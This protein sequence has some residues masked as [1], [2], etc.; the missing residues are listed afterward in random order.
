AEESLKSSEPVRLLIV[1]DTPY[2]RRLVLRLLGRD[3]MH[4]YDVTQA[5]HLGAALDLLETQAPFD[6]ILADYRLPDGISTELFE[7]LDPR[8]RPAVIVCSG[9]ITLDTAKYLLSLGVEDYLNKATLSVERLSVA[10]HNALFRRKHWHVTSSD[11]GGPSTPERERAFN[12]KHRRS[13]ISTLMRLRREHERYIERVAADLTVLNRGDTYR[14]IQ[15]L[16][17]SGVAQ[18]L[19]APSSELRM[20][21]SFLLEDLTALARTL[22]SQLDDAGLRLFGELHAC[23]TEIQ[24]ATDY[25]G[26]VAQSLSSV[27]AE[28]MVCDALVAEHLM[29]QCMSAVA[30][31]LSYDISLCMDPRSLKQPVLAND[32]ALTRVFVSLFG[33]TAHHYLSQSTPS[34]QAVVDV[35]VRTREHFVS[36]VCT[37]YVHRP[38][39]ENSHRLSLPLHLL[40][41]DDDEFFEIVVAADLVHRMGGSLEIEPM[42]RGKGSRTT[43]TLR[44]HNVTHELAEQTTPDVMHFDLQSNRAGGS[45]SPKNLSSALLVEDN[46]GDVVLFQYKFERQFPGVPLVAV[47]TLSEA[48]ERVELEEPELVFLDLHLP[49]ARGNESLVRLLSRFPW[50]DVI[51]LSGDIEDDTAMAALRSGAQD[52]LVKGGFTEQDL[53]RS[54][55]YA[56][57]RGSRRG[58]GDEVETTEL[59]IGVDEVASSL[60]TELRLHMRALHDVRSMLEPAAAGRQKTIAQDEARVRRLSAAIDGLTGLSQALDEGGEFVEPRSVALSDAVHGAMR[61]YVQ[62]RHHDQVTIS[63][64]DVFVFGELEQLERVVAVAVCNALEARSSGRVT[65]EVRW[66]ADAHDVTLSVKDDGPGMTEEQHEQ[67]FTPFYSTKAGHRGMGL[68]MVRDAVRAMGG[69]VEVD[70]KYGAGT[71]VL[72]CLPIAPPQQLA[73]RHGQHKNTSVSKEQTDT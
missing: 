56:L 53:R 21:V 14:R 12:A 11:E 34:A 71:S 47:A 70:T 13:S 55:N 43:I 62:P 39:L 50:L 67:C 20:N 72:I 29:K 15:H 16:V 36:F 45:S 60:A 35:E 68:P 19:N 57:A 24:R 58:G 32:E 28:R 46:P 40:R 3:T 8:T 63:G 23:A 18:E 41:Y 37:D 6:I 54:V 25:V 52:Y 66:E 10:I 5:D 4:E 44:A 22:N 73:A 51:V 69:L 49:D 38:L 9:T 30:D 59:V 61:R 64:E 7:A 2:D 1:E 65:V 33:A 31:Q 27:Q 42:R 17:A 26:D 48:L